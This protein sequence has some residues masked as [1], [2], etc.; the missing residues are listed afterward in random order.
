[1]FAWMANS[2]I[3]STLTVSRVLPSPVCD[4]K[5][6]SPV[7]VVRAQLRSTEFHFDSA[8]PTSV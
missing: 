8:Q 7:H 5:I 4:G 1:M 2:V 3:A 6:V